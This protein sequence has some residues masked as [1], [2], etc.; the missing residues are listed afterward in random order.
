MRS[1][2]PQESGVERLVAASMLVIFWAA[3]ASLA[4]GLSLWVMRHDNEW[5]ALL[6]VG[7]LLGLMVLPTLRLVA[8][9]ATASRERDWLTMWSTLAVLALLAALTL[10]DAATP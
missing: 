2:A 9:L 5:G 10:R 7:G 4:A 6:L 1:E 8:A 3:F